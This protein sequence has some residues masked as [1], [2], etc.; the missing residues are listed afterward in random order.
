MDQATLIEF[1]GI[2][3]VSNGPSL[4]WVEIDA[5][6]QGTG[7]NICG[8]TGIPSIGFCP[9]DTAWS[10]EFQP[11]GITWDFGT[12]HS[13]QLRSV[14][15]DQVLMIHGVTGQFFIPDLSGPT[16]DFTAASVLSSQGCDVDT[17]SFTGA[18]PAVPFSLPYTPPVKAEVR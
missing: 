11:N 13:W 17:S 7:A 2:L 12:S 16:A 9:N 6:G 1:Q 8:G 4:Q 3:P 15:N 18:R 5:V 10:A 14:A